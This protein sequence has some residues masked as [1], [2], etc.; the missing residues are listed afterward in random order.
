MSLIRAVSAALALAALSGPARAGD[1][2]YR[3]STYL[4]QQQCT[5]AG[6]PA[7]L[8]RAAWTRA[9]ARA[10][11]TRTLYVAMPLCEMRY[12]I[13]H[14]EGLDALVAPGD[15]RTVYGSAMVG[16]AVLRDPQSV[17]AAFLTEEPVYACP[18]EWA[19]APLCY[20]SVTGTI[21]ADRAIERPVS[22]TAYDTTFRNPLREIPPEQRGQ[23]NPVG[24][25]L[26]RYRYGVWS[27][28]TTLPLR[29]SLARA[30]RPSALTPYL[31]REPE[32]QVNAQGG[33]VRAVGTWLIQTT[34][35]WIP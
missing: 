27:F 11:E 12:G 13:G 19:Q 23:D 16:M 17:Q 25:R 29:E 2:D 32:L 26:I 3:W 8:C 15:R 24:S 35:T 18:Q 6:S 5:S 30:S 9:E 34:K 31:D 7:A 4:T 1:A 10:R 28:V 22:A 14:C 33:T 21:F 20:Q